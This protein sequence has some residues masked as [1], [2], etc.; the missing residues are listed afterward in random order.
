M[1]LKNRLRRIEQATEQDRQS[2]EVAELFMNSLA[3][4][5][6]L[7]NGEEPPPPHPLAGDP[8]Y[9]GTLLDGE[10]TIVGLAPG[11][12]VEDLSEN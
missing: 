6:S 5:K 2:E 9:K 12:A 4:L 11:E 10:H 8:R 7:A 1:G 3:R